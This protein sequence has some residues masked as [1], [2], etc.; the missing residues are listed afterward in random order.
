M[1]VG[2]GVGVEDIDDESDDVVVGA[3]I[4]ASVGAAVGAVV[5]GLGAETSPLVEFVVD[6]CE[7][8]LETRMWWVLAW[9]S[10]MAGERAIAAIAMSLIFIKAPPELL[11]V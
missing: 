1:G 9:P 6:E 2:V 4:G 7:P 11:I 8:S 5:V 3:A 10:T